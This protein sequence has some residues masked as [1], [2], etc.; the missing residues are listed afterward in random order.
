[1]SEST[2]AHQGFNSLA[3]GAQP[4]VEETD[5][6]PLKPNLLGYE[7][8]LCLLARHFRDIDQRLLQQQPQAPMSLNISFTEQWTGSYD[9]TDPEG[10]KKIYVKTIDCGAV[11]QNTEKIIA[12]GINGLRR[13]IHVSGRF[14]TA[15]GVPGGFPFCFTNPFYPTVSQACMLINFEAVRIITQVVTAES[16]ATIWYTKNE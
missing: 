12:H 5:R 14:G 3:W 11:A 13:V 9:E 8:L 16:R 4:S 6:Y 1:M 2:H 10:P 15:N 7:E